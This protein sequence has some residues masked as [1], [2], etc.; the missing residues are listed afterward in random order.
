MRKFLNLI[1]L[2]SKYHTKLSPFPTLGE[3]VFLSDYLYIITIIT[4]TTTVLLSILWI[5][6]LGLISPGPDFILC[7]N[8][9]LKRW[10]I[11]W[12]YTAV[13]IWLWIIIHISYCL[14]GIGVIISQSI[15]A[16][17]IIKV[18]WWLYLLYLAYNALQSDG[19]HWELNQDLDNNISASNA[20]S[21]IKQWFWTNVLN[22]KA[23]VFFVSLFSLI[24]WSQPSNL[25][26]IWI[27]LFMVISTIIRFS[28]VSFL[29]THSSIQKK[30]IKYSK[31]VDKAF[32]WLLVLFWLKLLFS[33]L[34]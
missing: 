2:Y 5:H 11:A 6:L 3:G 12:L 18:C 22:P 33:K 7:L 23:T 9:S 24:M 1:S 16:F 25:D 8:Q 15:I 10:R 28:T 4:M 13:W 29:L 32:G 17:S 30:Y 21:Y 27:C 20:L 26:I 34:S 14:I 19:Y 31:Y